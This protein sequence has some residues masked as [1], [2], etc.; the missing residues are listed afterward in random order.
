MDFIIQYNMLREELLQKVRAAVEGLPHQFVGLIPF[1]REIT[2]DAPIVGLDH[3]PYGSTSFVE[4]THA[5]GWQGLS[6]D[7]DK[8]SYDTACLYRNDMLNDAAILPIARAL[9]LLAAVKEDEQFF[10]RP[11]QDLKQFSGSIMAAREAVAFLE[12]AMLGAASGYHQL[13]PETLVVVAS[14]EEILA[15]WRWFVVGGQVIDGSLYRRNG[16][17]HKEH[18]EEARLVQQAQRLADRWLPSLCCVMDLALP[19][20]GKM[21]VVEFNCINGSGFYAHDVKKV[22]RAWWGYHNE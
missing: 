8:F 3:I 12:K 19:V 5:L 2:S 15:E 22:M 10:M 16:Q 1:S 6:F 11:N 14:P 13:S 9:L 4:T 7:V 17:A 21:K 20:G 18:V